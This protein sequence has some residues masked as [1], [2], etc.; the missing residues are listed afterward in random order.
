M[1]AALWA[2]AGAASYEDAVTRA[3]AL[4]GDTDSIAAIAGALAGAAGHAI[5]LAWIGAIEPQAAAAA[6]ALGD[7]LSRR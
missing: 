1:P 5:P 3:I 2:F 7:A 4:G 6:R